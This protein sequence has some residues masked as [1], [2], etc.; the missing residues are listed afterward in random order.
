[1]NDDVSKKRETGHGKIYGDA[2]NLNKNDLYAIRDIFVEAWNKQAKG[3]G[4]EMELSN[5]KTIKQN[6]Y[7][8]AYYDDK[9]KN[10]DIS[11]ELG[12]HLMEIETLDKAIDYFRNN[13]DNYLKEDVYN[14]LV[15][16]RGELNEQINEVQSG[17]ISVISSDL[18]LGDFEKTKVSSINDYIDLRNKIIQE[19]LNNDIVQRGLAEGYFDAEQKLVFD[20]NGEGYYEFISSDWLSEQVDNYLG[21]L[22]QFSEYYN[23]LILLHSFHF[24]LE[25]I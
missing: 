18:L 21:G 1:M 15:K 8:I 11:V 22:D 23:I 10:L 16:Y 4:F 3:S 19:L 9:K 20:E 6:G 12:S 7:N 2:K 17:L 25:G 13:I 24:F 5:E 14:K